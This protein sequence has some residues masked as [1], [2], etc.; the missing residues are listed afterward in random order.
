M[1]ETFTRLPDESFRYAHILV[2]QDEI[3]VEFLRNLYRLGRKV[4]VG[5]NQVFIVLTVFNLAR[6]S[7]PSHIL[8]CSSIQSVLTP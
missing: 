8:C 5:T 1:L 6:L 2:R 7:V 4:V 3:W